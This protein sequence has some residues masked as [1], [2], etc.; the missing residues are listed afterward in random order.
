[1]A[2]RQDDVNGV[3]EDIA[4]E[5]GFT[6]ANR[7]IMWFGGR[8]VSIP[9]QPS[10]DHPVAVVIGLRS[11]ERLR[12]AFGPCSVFIPAGKHDDVE[13]RDREIAALIA[14]GKGTRCIADAIGISESCVQKRRRHLEQ[15]GLLPLVLTGKIGAKPERSGGNA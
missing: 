7:L 11:L 5:I 9:A 10:E 1:M 3:M 4:A 8:Q 15:T 13:L 6:A 2:Y 14:A 12:Q